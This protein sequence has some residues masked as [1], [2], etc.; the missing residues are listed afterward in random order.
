MSSD[1]VLPVTATCSA[2]ST[3]AVRFGI[4]CARATCGLN[5]LRAVGVGVESSGFVDCMQPARDRPARIAAAIPRLRVMVLRSLECPPTGHSVRETD[6]DC[7]GH[8]GGLPVL[9]D[10]MR[11]K[12][13]LKPEG[14]G[15]CNGAISKI[16]PHGE[17]D[18]VASRKRVVGET[19]RALQ[20][21]MA[22]AKSEERER[23]TR[24]LR[25]DRFDSEQECR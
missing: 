19:P 9:Y 22:D 15:A 4:A 23:S 8:G 5:T 21:H 24:C 3:E 12:C 18:I 1:T 14:A 13:G 10:G 17:P 11:S 6:A 25:V 7:C 20:G 16:G 2:T